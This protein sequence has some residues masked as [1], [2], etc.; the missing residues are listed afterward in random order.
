MH[1]RLRDDRAEAGHAI[2]RELALDAVADKLG[3][4][5][6]DEE[7]ETFVR[8]QAD[9]AGDDAEETLATLRE[10]GTF[11]SLR[12]D[13]RLRKALDEVA[14][15]VQRIPVELAAARDKLWTP[16]KEKASSG[17]NIWTP[18]SEEAPNR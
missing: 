17:M 15:G 3:L 2:T 1:D 5:V 6:T 8:E 13:L 18:G 11:E 14:A 4:E 16:E 9:G 7:I 10:R 12:G